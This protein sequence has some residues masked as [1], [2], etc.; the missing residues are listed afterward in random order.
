MEEG[1]LSCARIAD[2]RQKA[3]RR[4]GGV[5]EGVQSFS[6]RAAR[7]EIGTMGRDAKGRF[8]QLEEIEEHRTTSKTGRSQFTRFGGGEGR[9][10][11]ANQGEVAQFRVISH[12]GVIVRG[13]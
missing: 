13:L 6:M 7:V 9:L 2:E 10:V 8:S 4:A 3:A 11:C 1:G 12:S 5:R